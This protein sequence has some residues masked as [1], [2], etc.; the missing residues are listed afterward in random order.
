VVTLAIV[1]GIVFAGV[2]V[3]EFNYAGGHPHAYGPAK[4]IAWGGVA[5]AV[6]SVAVGL[7]GYVPHAVRASNVAAITIGPCPRHRFAAPDGRRQS[8]R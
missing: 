7:L 6:V 1:A 8:Q 5:G 4:V 3:H 2:A